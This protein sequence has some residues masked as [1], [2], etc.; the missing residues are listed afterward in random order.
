MN[1]VYKLI[2]AGSRSWEDYEHIKL[3]VRGFYLHFT[4]GS[5]ALEIVSGTARGADRLGEKLAR[6]HQ[7]G[8]RR[9]PAEWEVYGR[10]AGYLRNEKMADYADGAIVFWD[11]ESKG[12]LHMARIAKARGLDMWLVSPSGNHTESPPA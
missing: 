4:R 3:R 1:D 5:P 9:F 6:D 8:L 10:R 11:G 2:I 12:S 7:L